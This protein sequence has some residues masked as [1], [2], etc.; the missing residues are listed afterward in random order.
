MVVCPHCGEK[1]RKDDVLVVSDYLM[2]QGQLL[3]K[4]ALCCVCGFVLRVK[5]FGEVVR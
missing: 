4:Y 1:L 5:K 2:P 3:S